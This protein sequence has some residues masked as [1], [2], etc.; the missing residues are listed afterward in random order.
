VYCHLL[1][2]STPTWRGFH[3]T[4]EGSQCTV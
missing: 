2:E 4:L 3:E 1:A